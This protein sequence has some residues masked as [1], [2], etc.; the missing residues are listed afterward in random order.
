MRLKGTFDDSDK[1]LVAVSEIVYQHCGAC[2]C[3]PNPEPGHGI[4]MGNHKW[5]D[6]GQIF[7]YMIQN[8]W[9][10]SREVEVPR[11]MRHVP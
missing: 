1:H 9:M 11:S 4:D 2:P 7:F 8:K 3:K 6:S 5:I 10:E